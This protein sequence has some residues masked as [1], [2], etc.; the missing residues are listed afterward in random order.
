MTHYT[1]AIGDVIVEQRDAVFTC[2][3]LGSCIGL[4]ISDRDKNLSAAAHILLPDDE[5][6]TSEK[7]KF[8]TVTSALR[9]ILNQFKQRGSTLYALRAKIT[10]GANV[11]NL[12]TQRGSANVTSVMKHLNANRIFVAAHDVG[13]VFSRTAKYDSLTGQLTIKIPEL[14]DYKFF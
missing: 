6:A 1:V 12:S 2:F 9:Q 8:Y 5:K 10:G 7:D 3:G 11:V 4:F 13:G 14:N